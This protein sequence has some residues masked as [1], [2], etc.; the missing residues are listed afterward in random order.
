MLLGLL[1]H[2]ATCKWLELPVSTFNWDLST[3]ALIGLNAEE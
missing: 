2:R 1:R 3:R